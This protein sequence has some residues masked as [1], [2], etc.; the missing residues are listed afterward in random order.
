M[1]KLPNQECPACRAKK[2]TLMQDE[3]DIPFFGKTFVFSM[4]CDSCGFKK[5]DIEAA[6]FKEPC[7][8]ELDIVGKDDLN[9]RVVKSSQATVKWPDF[10]ITID[11][12]VSAEGF[13]ANI[14]K[15]LND[16]QKVLEF[17]KETEEDKAKKKRMRKMI[18]K[19][20]DIKDGREKTKLIIED[21][22]GNS[23]IISRKAVKSGL[24]KTKAK[25]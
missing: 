19:I 2:L 17:N 5:S 4:Q 22:T 11:P 1:E 23:A 10:K 13:V 12:G 7:R 18:D 6:E 8:Y 21:P 20:L 9:I 24:K 14:E 25:K 15:M 16:I 3:L